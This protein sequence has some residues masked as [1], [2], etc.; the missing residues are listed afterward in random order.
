MRKYLVA[1]FFAFFFNLTVVTVFSPPQVL[2]A[3]LSC[4]PFG[5]GYIGAPP[6]GEFDD[7][8][9]S[10]TFTLEGLTPN[11]AFSVTATQSGCAFGIDTCPS[12]PVG[13]TTS[14]ASGVATFNLSGGSIFPSNL[15]AESGL[16]L[17][18]TG[19][20]I[21]SDGCK[22]HS[23]YQ[24]VSSV[25]CDASSILISQ[26]RNGQECFYEE[27]MAGAC[28]NA[29]DPVSVRLT[30][31]RKGGS[32]YSGP[33]QINPSWR[34]GNDIEMQASSGNTPF[35]DITGLTIGGHSVGVQEP[36]SASTACSASLTVSADCQ[37]LCITEDEVG[38]A[39][40]LGPDKFSLCEQINDETA[41]QKCLQCS[42]GE[43]GTEGI[44]TAVGCIS[45]EPEEIL[46]RFI[47]LGISMGG[48]IALLMILSAGFTMTVSQGNAQ[49]TAQAK[50]MM[51]AAITGLLF[52]IFSVTILQFIGFSILKIP[53]FGG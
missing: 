3:E 30:N 15:N 8:N 34:V 35:V 46:G 5:V 23:P 6:P 18:L 53:G 26:Q 21:D 33:I 48:G 12:A 43:D 44:W 32:L 16:A 45:K 39:E 42:G 4:T 10:M 36:N 47:R 51:T 20:G 13:G 7:P 17:W 49:K 40:N 28:L 25:V 50:E 52:I 11:S 24:L 14:N 29:T 22:L 37:E 41:Q 31:L 19:T 27:N 1:L 38:E 2:A 9:S